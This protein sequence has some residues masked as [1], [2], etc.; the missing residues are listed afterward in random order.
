MHDE[1]IDVAQGPEYVPD[2]LLAPLD[3]DRP[4]LCGIAELCEAYAVS[5][6]VDAEAGRLGVES[7]DPLVLADEVA[8]AGRSYSSSTTLMMTG[9]VPMR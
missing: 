4:C 7:A 9:S 8:E 5:G 2:Q 1:L 6:L 3:G